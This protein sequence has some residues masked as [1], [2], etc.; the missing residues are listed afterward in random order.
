MAG[1]GHCAQHKH[2]KLACK[3]LILVG[4]LKSQWM[5]DFMSRGVHKGGWHGMNCF[6]NEGKSLEFVSEFISHSKELAVEISF[7]HGITTKPNMYAASWE[8]SA[9]ESNGLP[10]V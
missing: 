10:R 8:G 7:S 4:H 9:F 6:R 5:D 2:V 1:S 3:A